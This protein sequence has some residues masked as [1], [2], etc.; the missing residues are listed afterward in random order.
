MANELYRTQITLDYIAIRS[1]LS[2]FF[3]AN[4]LTLEDPYYVARDINANLFSG[5]GWLYALTGLI[6]NGIKFTR[7]ST[8]RI[9]PGGAVTYV[10]PIF[11]GAIAGR[12]PGF[13]QQ[14]WNAAWLKWHSAVD[15]SGKHGVRLGPLPT[16]VFEGTSYP[17]GFV[18][19]ANIFI[20]Q[21]A[22]PRATTSGVDFQGAI[23][24][25]DLTAEIIIAGQL[26]IP[27]SR[28]IQR[29]WVP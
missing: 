24:H 13:I 5:F 28:Q 26:G 23:V 6:G 20:S 1:T 9:E 29:R 22:S 27:K 4:N 10:D 12:F 2:F 11:E 17:I 15:R 16:Q 25:K 14:T 7:V 19:N 21:H 8:R 18:T 3:I